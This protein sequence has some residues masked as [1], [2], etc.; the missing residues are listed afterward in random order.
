M[1]LKKA[2]SHQKMHQAVHNWGWEIPS[3]GGQCSHQ[4]EHDDYVSPC[5]VPGTGVVCEW[6]GASRLGH[7][8]L[9]GDSGESRGG[10]YLCSSS[11]GVGPSL[12]PQGSVGD[13]HEKAKHT[14]YNKSAQ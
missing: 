9:R 14:C 7:H 12:E 3:W 1:S 13:D 4:W 6:E 11:Q 8:P 5:H 2:N 10:L